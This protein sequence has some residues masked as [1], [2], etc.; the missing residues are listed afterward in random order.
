MG[1]NFKAENFIVDAY[2]QALLELYKDSYLDLLEMLNKFPGAQ[3]IA[4][5]IAFLDCPTPPLFNPGFDDFFKSLQLPFCRNMNPITFP[6]WENPFLYIPKLSDILKAIFEAL[7]RLVFCLIMR[8]IVLIMAKI[9]EIIADAICKLLET[10]GQIGAGLLTGNANVR[11]IIKST[12]C[13]PNA[14]D[15]T[16][17]NTILELMENFGVGGAAFADPERT[18]SFF[19]D[20]INSSTREEALNMFVERSI[21]STIRYC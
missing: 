5:I 17:D 12:I 8:I 7:K 20:F 11:E 14:D 6:R 3:L 18:V 16:V 13:G 4:T 10:A 19:G 9:C 2:I 21:T 1:E 15:E